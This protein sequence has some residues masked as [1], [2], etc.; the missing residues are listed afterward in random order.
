MTSRTYNQQ[1]QLPI[2]RYLNFP[3]NW[4]PTGIVHTYMKEKITTSN[5]LHT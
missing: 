5:L 3:P 1:Q 4:A 2:D